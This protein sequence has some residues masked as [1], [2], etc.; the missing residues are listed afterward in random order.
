M[1]DL[2]RGIADVNQAIGREQ[3]REEGIDIGQM[4]TLTNLVNKGRLTKEEAAE[5]CNLTVDE[6]LKKKEEYEKTKH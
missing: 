5:E 6:F 3:G 1:C 4:Q 2:S